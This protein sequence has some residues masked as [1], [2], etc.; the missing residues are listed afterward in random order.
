MTDALTKI[1]LDTVQTVPEVLP[2]LSADARR[3]VKLHAL[4]A[5][6][7]YTSIRAEMSGEIHDAIYDYLTSSG[8][9]TIYKALVAA[10]ISKADAAAAD[11]GYQDAGAE[12][13]LDAETAAWARAELD[14][15]LGFV[16]QLFENLRELRKEGDV[17]ATAEAL[18]RANGYASGLDGFYNEAGL[19]GAKNKVPT[20]TQRSDTKESC[21]DC[22][23]L[24][25]CRVRA[26]LSAARGSAPTQG[27]RL[28]C[29]PGGNCG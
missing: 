29:A 15:Q 22:V 9:I 28:A 18:A 19:R 17:N 6:G 4:K 27:R 7:D 2:Y 21:P 14:S 3:F 25:G 1:V 11:A 24:R 8:Y 5:A 16:D 20:F 26:S 13:P 12:L 10:A 23:R